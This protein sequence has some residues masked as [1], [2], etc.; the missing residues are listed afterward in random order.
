LEAYSV[1]ERFFC[2]SALARRAFATSRSAFAWLS[3]LL[4]VRGSTWI[5]RAP[6][7]TS[8]PVSTFMARISPEALDFTSTVVSGWIA[9]LARADTTMS[10]RSTA[11]A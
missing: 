1:S 10:R 7:C 9:P 11:M 5:S 8:E 6:R 4:A 3:E 2:D